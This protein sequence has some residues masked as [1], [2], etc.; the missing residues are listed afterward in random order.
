M[1]VALVTWRRHRVHAHQ[2]YRWHHPGEGAAAGTLEG[3]AAPPGAAPR[4]GH[5]SGWIRP[6]GTGCQGGR[7]QHR[8]PGQCRCPAGHGDGRTRAAPRSGWVGAGGGQ[9][10]HGSC[11]GQ[12]PTPPAPAPPG[13]AG[14]SPTTKG[15]VP[16]PAEASAGRW[17]WAGRGAAPGRGHGCHGGSARRCGTATTVQHGGGRQGAVAPGQWGQ[18][19]TV[20]CSAK[21][22]GCRHGLV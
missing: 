13:T 1:A 20:P 17:P 14:T 4:P 19:H 7:D 2:S 5:A 12:G 11:R 22:A 10:G 16:G 18:H 6:P 21:A 15:T 9:P 8:G 3:R